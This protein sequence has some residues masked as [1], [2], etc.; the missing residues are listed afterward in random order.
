[1]NKTA[2][3]IVLLFAFCLLAAQDLQPWQYI[4]H[5]AR[6]ADGNVHFR[7]NG[8][9]SVLGNYE[10]WG[11]QNNAWASFPLTSPEALTYEALVPYTM[12]TDFKYRLK[13][14]YELSGQ[15][16]TA[17]NPAFLDTDTFPPALSSL[18]YIADDPVGDSINTYY[19]NLDLTGSWCGWSSD[20]LY[21]ALSNT[22]NSFPI[23]NSLTSYNIYFSGLAASISN[24]LQS[25][26]YAM[27]YTFNVPNVISPGLYK[28][29][30]NLADTSF[31][32]TRLGNIQSQVSGGH[33]FLACNIA[34][35]TADPD[36][37]TWP[38]ANNFLGS[39]SGSIRLNMDLSTLTPSFVLGDFSGLAQFIFQDLRYQS[40]RNSLPLILEPYCDNTHAEFTYSDPDGDF[41]LTAKFIMSE[42]QQEF[43]FVS[44]SLD[45]SQPVQMTTVYQV[46]PG[47]CPIISVSDDNINFREY[48]FGDA[49]EDE[50]LPAA[51]TCRVY[52]NP[53][54]PSDGMLAVVLSG[55]KA[56]S[57]ASIYNLKGRLVNKLQCV[58]T[59]TETILTWD[60][61]Q[62]NGKPAAEGIYLVKVTQGQKSFAEKVI[63]LR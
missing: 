20:K 32:Y 48:I 50:T 18:A 5:S 52:P 62:A 46:G 1:M 8:S 55:S 53:F 47:L 36:F 19:A 57:S 14:G 59:G 22:A 58:K 3:I 26:V 56:S 42:L 63:L 43:D 30:F 44:S 9:P 21:L 49:N 37:G 27:V 17:L 6:D 34:D 12:G 10:F 16:V 13:T 11:W 23:M 38:P 29:N 25:G 51:I 41:P 28:L 54:K 2:A 60:G 40:T 35:L 45:F 24:L 33:L 39:M 7:F 61:L 15:S 4:R 31:T